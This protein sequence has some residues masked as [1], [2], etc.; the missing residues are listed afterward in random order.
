MQPNTTPL[1]IFDIDGTLCN[2]EHRL[3]YLET[4]DWDSFYKACEDD[5]PNRPVIEVLNTL[6]ASGADI[7]LFSGR[8]EIVREETIRWLSRYTYYP[9]HELRRNETLLT[10]RSER[11]YTE[12]HILKESWLHFMLKEDIDRLV[13][14]FDDRKRVVDMWRSHGIACFQVAPGE[15]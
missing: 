2:I 7:Y 4:K 11:D 13:G 8:S 10:M 14:V 6:L 9:I 1:Y 12:D 3:H 15:F 5:Q